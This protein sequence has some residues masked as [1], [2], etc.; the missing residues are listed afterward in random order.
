MVF[1]GR[2]SIMENKKGYRP[3]K[4]THID[5]EALLIYIMKHD[6]TGE[7]TSEEFGIHRVTISKK[8]KELEEK[9]KKEENKELSKIISLYKE[10]TS[11]HRSH[12]GQMNKRTQFV[13]RMLVEKP[14]FI[15]GKLDNTMENLHQREEALKQSENNY[16]QAA[17]QLGITR[18]ALTKTIGNKERIKKEFEKE[19]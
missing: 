1:K 15:K 6:L 11:Y 8:V 13:I 4:Y 18:Q 19:R 12:K 3:R 9:A 10:Y 14:V 16:T 7:Q 17:K 2:D 5:Y